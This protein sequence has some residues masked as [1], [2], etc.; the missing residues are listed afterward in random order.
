VSKQRWPLLLL[1]MC[2]VPSVSGANASTNST[3]F[4]FQV[5]VIGAKVGATPFFSYACKDSRGAG[6]R[7]TQVFHP[8]Y[9][10]KEVLSIRRLL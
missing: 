7:P 9:P 4:K 3:R 10:Y 5:K 2:A 1:I 8:K 6:F